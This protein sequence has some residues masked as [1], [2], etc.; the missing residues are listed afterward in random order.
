MNIKLKILSTFFF[1]SS[2]IKFSVKMMKLFFD[3][4][5]PKT[6]YESFYRDG[7]F[8]VHKN[9]IKYHCLDKWKKLFDIYIKNNK[10]FTRDNTIELINLLLKETDKKYLSSKK[11]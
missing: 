6:E 3:N 8:T 5:E 7:S 9:I 10:I 2:H 1:D 4:Y 11:N